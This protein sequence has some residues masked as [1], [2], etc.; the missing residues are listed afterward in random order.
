MQKKLVGPLDDPTHPSMSDDPTAS[1]KVDAPS[2]DATVHVLERPQPDRDVEVRGRR[3]RM[4]AGDGFVGIWDLRTG[5]QVATFME[6][7]SDTAA[8]RFAEL[9]ANSPLA[10]ALARAGAV[11]AGSWYVVVVIVLGALSVAYLRLADDS[12][13][14]TA[15]AERPPALRAR[16]AAPLDEAGAAVATELVPR[17][18]LP[19]S[20]PSDAPHRPESDRGSGSRSSSQGGVTVPEPTTSPTVGGGNAPGTGG[21]TNH[22]HDGGNGGGGGGSGGNSSPPPTTPPPT[23]PPTP[24][25]TPDEPSGDPATP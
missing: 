2:S 18:L 17:R 13:T 1:A 14:P 24:Q 10:N 23:T 3:Y 7:A 8:E 20:S 11:L 22:S 19:A 15:A 9:E 16:A 25:P 12:L 6:D 21:G 4:A 5:E